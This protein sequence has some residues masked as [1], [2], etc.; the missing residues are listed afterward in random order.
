MKAKRIERKIKAVKR[1]MIAV[2]KTRVVLLEG[3]KAVVVGKAAG[4]AVE[5]EKDGVGVAWVADSIIRMAKEASPS[6]VKQTNTDLK[7]TVI[8]VALDRISHDHCVN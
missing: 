8:I 4:T 6:I 7:S 5:A 3:G 2:S 1:T